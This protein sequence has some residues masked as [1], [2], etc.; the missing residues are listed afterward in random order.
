MSPFDFLLLAHFLADFPLQ[1]SWMAMNKM[2]KWFPLIVHSTIYT[3]TLG[4]IAFFGFGGLAW[5]QLLII[6]SAHS[7]LDR[8]TFVTWWIRHVMRTDL[9]WLSIMVDQVF[10]LTILAV[11][12]QLS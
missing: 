4:V 2:A 10:H 5:W 1:N 9:P 12:V 3:A 6:F 11:I 7:L 8:R